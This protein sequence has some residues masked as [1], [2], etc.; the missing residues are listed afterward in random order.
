[1]KNLSQRQELYFPVADSTSHLKTG[2]TMSSQRNLCS[3]FNITPMPLL[4]QQK[5]MF[6]IPTSIQWMQIYNVITSLLC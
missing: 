6:H 2:D 1:M 5:G 4:F 3:C